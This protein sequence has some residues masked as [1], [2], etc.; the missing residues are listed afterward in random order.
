MPGPTPPDYNLSITET[1]VVLLWNTSDL[2][3]W[4]VPIVLPLQALLLRTHTLQLY[5]YLFM[6][7]SYWCCFP[8]TSLTEDQLCLVVRMLACLRQLSRPPEVLFSS[9]WHLCDWHTLWEALGWRA[10]SVSTHCVVRTLGRIIVC[11]LSSVR[12]STRRDNPPVSERAG[13]TFLTQMSWNHR[14][15]V[16]NFRTEKN[17]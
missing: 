7:F 14:I 9:L 2:F 5:S 17:V 15:L 11:S 3:Y 6:S 12:W 4:S 16:C 10:D 8:H 1:A 13:L